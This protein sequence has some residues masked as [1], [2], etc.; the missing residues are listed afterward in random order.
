MNLSFIFNPQKS[1]HKINTENCSFF[2]LFFCSLGVLND[3]EKSV[4]FIPSS[5]TSIIKEGVKK[6]KKNDYVTKIYYLEF[7]AQKHVEI[8]YFYCQCCEQCRSL[9]F[10]YVDDEFIFRS[11]RKLTRPD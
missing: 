10:E 9:M 1:W 11:N 5:Q 6:K 4:G 8:T 7:F 3:N 2:G